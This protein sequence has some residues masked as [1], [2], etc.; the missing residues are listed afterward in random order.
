M[1]RQ[2]R[3]LTTPSEEVAKTE[4]PVRTRF[5]TR[6]SR[7]QRKTIRRA[8]LY[9]SYQQSFDKGDNYIPQDWT[10]SFLKPVAKSDEH[11]SRFKEGIAETYEAG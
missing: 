5:D 8:E 9:T 4:K 1:K 2:T 7:T 11:R 3:I 10:D 6:I